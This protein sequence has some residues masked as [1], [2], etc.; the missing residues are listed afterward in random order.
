MN[1]PLL[2]ANLLTA[3]AFLIHTFIGDRELKLNEPSGDH[4]P[5]HEK[6]EKWTMAR[7]GWHWVSV[8]LLFATLALALVNFTNYVESKSTLLYVLSAYFLAYSVAWALTIA[9]SPRFPQRY[10]KL[11]QWLLL[12]LISALIYRGAP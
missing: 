12:L 8:D 1:L 6:R 9:I 5:K 4:D 2:T 7:C 11:G 3:L 10:L